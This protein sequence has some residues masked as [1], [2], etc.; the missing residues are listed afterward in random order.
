MNKLFSFR[1]VYNT[2]DYERVLENRVKHI[3]EILSNIIDIEFYTLLEVYMRL[4][5]DDS[6]ILTTFYSSPSSLFK[7]DDIEA[8]IREHNNQIVFDIED[9]TNDDFGWVVE[10]VKMLN[11]T[12]IEYNPL[13]EK[14]INLLPFAKDV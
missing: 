4:P 11:S 3:S 8:E 5:F 14:M 9:Y 6:P 10:N 12:I 7:D 13:I 1:P 2:F